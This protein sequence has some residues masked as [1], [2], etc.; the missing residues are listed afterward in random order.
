MRRLRRALFAL[1]A[2]VALAAIP[3][4]RGLGSRPAR[5]A[6]ALRRFAL[7]A[8]NDRGGPGTR[9]LLYATADAR[10]V[11]EI[12]TR[13][14]NVRADD[15]ILLENTDA[16]RFWGTLGQ[17]EARARDAA[18]HGAKTALVVY[19]SGHAK[20][21]A[22][23]LGDSQLPLDA[24][25]ARLAAAPVDVRIGIFDSCRSGAMTR[26]KGARRAPAFEV[27][28]QAQRA[29]RGTVILTSSSAD[30]DSQ[31]SD[32][33]GGSYF[34]HH[35]AS[36]PARRRRQ[37]GRRA[38]HF[39]GGVCLRVRAHGRGHRGKRRRRAAPDLQLRPGRQRGSGPDR[40]RHA[41]RGTA[42]AGGGAE[43]HVL[44]GRRARSGRR[45]D[46]EAG[47]RRAARGA[48]A[49]A[50]PRQAPPARSPAHRRGRHPEGTA[51]GAGRGA[52][53]RRAVF[54]RSGQGRRAR[55]G[56]VDAIQLGHRGRT[57]DDV[58]RAVRRTVP[59]GGLV[60]SRA[61]P[62]QLPAPRLG[63]VVRAVGRQ[64]QAP[65]RPADGRVLALP[66]QRGVGRDVDPGGVAASRRSGPLRGRPAGV[67]A[68]VAPVR[69]R[70]R[71]TTSSSPP[72]RRASSRARA[73][74][75]STACRWWR[76][77]ACTTC[78]T[79]SRRTVGRSGIGSSAASCNST[80]AATPPEAP[81]E[82]ESNRGPDAGRDG[83]HRRGLWE[84]LQRGS[85]VHERDPAR[86]RSDHRGPRQR[87]NAAA[88]GGG[89]GMSHHVP[90][91][92]VAE[93]GGRRVLAPGGS[94]PVVLSHEAQCRG[95]RVGPVPLR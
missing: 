15:A 36:R 29:A 27:D 17:L 81:H 40:R 61:R 89:R 71:A 80:L 65:G 37:V 33:I 84:L 46:R 93:R 25:K 94:H 54:G 38:R 72:R 59:V 66:L 26:T 47:G 92:A 5:A 1:L 85:R 74:A 3:G 64:H 78:S 7:I 48:V 51:G 31:E 12:L 73:I 10:K 39:V 4:A 23:R 32:A 41:P 6:E 50:L 8:G 34:S 30:E 60:E 91:H 18:A 14:G 24:L 55:P 2:L 53:D 63:V 45:R 69:R 56:S 83:G 35:L 90:D 79:T 67:V 82:V 20:D 13:L 58:R 49:R 86:R 22:L 88:P 62:A 76:A 16:N 9:P 28:T 44:P 21:G 11:W 43:R 95:P 57:A 77:V 52:P 70:R 42:V 75:C 68:D 87:A 19:F